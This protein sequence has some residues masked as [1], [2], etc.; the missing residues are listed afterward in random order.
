M[1]PRAAITVAITTAG[2]AI[3]LGLRDRIDPWL[4]TAMAGGVGIGLS[5]WALGPRLHALLACRW[6]GVAIA[7]GLGVALIVA[8]HGAYAVAARVAPALTDEV[9][10]LYATIAVGH[11][12][13]PLVGLTLVVVLAEEL[14]WRGAALELSSAPRR[15]VGGG[16]VILYALPQALAGA[17]LLVIAALGLGSLLA[18]QRLL[19]GRL[20][21]PF[22]THAV[23]SLAI[24]VVLPLGG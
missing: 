6:R 24:F 4:S 21:E 16:A 1:N 14:V 3:S 19:T 17:W 23:W 2:F 13:I 5:M 8:T 15:W 9:R 22:V 7:A 18:A 20:T 12:R 10:Q 11:G